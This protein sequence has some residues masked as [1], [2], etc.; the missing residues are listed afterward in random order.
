MGFVG[1]QKIGKKLGVLDFP[2]AH[3]CSIK[4]IK[5]IQKPVKL[6]EV[7]TRDNRID[8]IKVVHCY[9]SNYTNENFTLKIK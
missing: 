2:S 5:P 3:V 6:D 8:L 4:N 7:W 9:D 1:V